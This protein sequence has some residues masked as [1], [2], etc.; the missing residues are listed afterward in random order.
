MKVIVSD[1]PFVKRPRKTRQIMI[2]MTISLLPAWIAGI[3]FFGWKAFLVPALSTITAFLTEMIYS[4]C[5]RKNIK[6]FF[7]EFDFTSIVTGVLLGLCLSSEVP[8]YVP[9]LS[10]IFAVAAVKMLFGGTGKNIANP[11][12]CGRIFA[13]IAF[14]ALMGSWGKAVFPPVEGYIPAGATALTKMLGKG[15]VQ[16]MRLTNLDL[17]L[18]AGVAGC[19]GETCKVAVIIGFLY[20]AVRKIIR[21]EY[22]LTVIAATGLTTVF[23][24]GADF[25][26]FL[27][28]VL[29]GGLMFGAVFMATD[30]T[31]CPS[32][33]G[34]AYL[35]FLCMGVLTAVLRKATGIEVVSFAILLM[36]L[37]VPLFDLHLRPR[38]FGTE[39]KFPFKKRKEAGSK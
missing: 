36:N 35:Y 28:S 34:A 13:F 11:A 9:I 15:G 2:E 24:N 23:L 6:E 25:S 19:I 21:W 12:I 8:W 7:A 20:L 30:Y 5:L 1:S 27:P 26:Y 17:F 18:G 39:R 14:P 29:S 33:R 10:S 32:T 31:T 16:S 38:P 37:L 22:P 4:L 3:V